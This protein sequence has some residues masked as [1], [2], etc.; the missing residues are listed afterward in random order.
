MAT[1]IVFWAAEPVVG[2]FGRRLAFGSTAHPDKRRGTS[3]RVYLCENKTASPLRLLRSCSENRVPRISKGRFAV[4]QS[5]PDLTGGN[6]EHE[7]VIARSCSGC[8]Q[9]TARRFSQT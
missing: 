4:W 3:R 5:T 8:N 7:R 9:P 6:P 1:Q 2:C